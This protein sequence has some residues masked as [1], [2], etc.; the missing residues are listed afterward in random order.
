VTVIAWDGKT[1]AADRQADTDGY[2]Y[3]VTKIFDCGDMLVGIAGHFARGTAMMEWLRNGK[4]GAF[5]EEKNDDWCMLLVVY[6]DG[7]IERYESR[8]L[9]ILV[10]ERI[11]SAGSGRE[12]A[13]MALHLGLSAKEAVEKT[14]ELSNQCGGGIDTLSFEDEAEETASVLSTFFPEFSRRNNSADAGGSNE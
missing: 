4:E 14:C 10:E 7:R 12:F 5:P 2:A 13:M 1:L 9:P 11:H 3:S 6:R 8:P